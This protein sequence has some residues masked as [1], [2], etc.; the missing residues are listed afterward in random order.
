MKKR[1]IALIALLVILAMLASG[2]MFSAFAANNFTDVSA[3]HWAKSDIDFAANNGI[4]NGYPEWDGS[5]TFK[6]QAGVTYEEAATMLYRALRAAGMLRE[7][8]E[9]ALLEKYAFEL[10]AAEIAAWARTYVAYGLEFGLID[11]SEL[12]LFVNPVTKLGNPAPRVSVAIW[13]AKALDKPFAG[14]YYMPYTDASAITDA[15]APYIDMLYR[16]GIMK[17]SL[18]ADG[19][20]AF[21]PSSGVKRCEFAAI[22]N[23]V[24]NNVNA[25][26]SLEKESYTYEQ[27]IDGTTLRLNKNAVT[28]GSSSGYIAVTGMTGLDGRNPQ[29]IYIG[30]PSMQRGKIKDVKKIDTSSSVITITLSGKDIQYI[31]NKS[32]VSASTLKAGSSITFIADG[33]YLL[34]TK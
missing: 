20:I 22:A 1:S 10:D 28:T 12:P 25:D 23:R 8:D 30:G 9:N 5:F 14:L 32:T 27:K 31:S 33:I 2:S 16:H 15:Q 13:T 26:Y 3:S 29:V 21:Q 17:G 18:Q 4:V 34:E 19:S 6:P 24:F 7:A 11:Q